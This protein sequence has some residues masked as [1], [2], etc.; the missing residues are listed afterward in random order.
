MSNPAT[1][2]GADELARRRAA[3]LE[4]IKEGAWPWRREAVELA[5]EA[6]LWARLAIQYAFVV[7]GG[8]L[9]FLPVLLSHR[10]TFAV[11]P[12]AIFAATWWFAGGILAAALCCLLAYLNFDAHASE[13]W[14]MSGIG[15]HDAAVEHFKDAKAYEVS[16]N[17]RKAAIRIARLQRPTAIGGMVLGLAAYVGFVV[18]VVKLLLR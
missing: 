7:N 8:A 3:Y 14:T 12:V 2:P 1:G 9:I 5:K 11:P 16:S 17:H 4:E 6:S 10:D 18:G 13:R 15:M